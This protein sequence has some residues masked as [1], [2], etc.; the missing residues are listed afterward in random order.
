MDVERPRL[1]SSA[2]QAQEVEPIEVVEEDRKAGDAAGGDVVYA[3]FRELAARTTR[4]PSRVV[5]RE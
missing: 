2:E 5:A 1:P 4:H 3:V